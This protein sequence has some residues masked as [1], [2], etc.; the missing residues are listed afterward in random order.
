M[1]DTGSLAQPLGTATSGQALP[2]VVFSITVAG[3]TI[4]A[5]KFDIVGG[6]YGSTGHVQ[7]S[8]SQTALSDAN[9]DL[10]EIT[11]S[12]PGFVEVDITV[13]TNQQGPQQG[14]VTTTETGGPGT[15]QPNEVRIFGGEYLNTKWHMDTDEVVIRARDWSGQLVDQKRILTKIGKAVESALHPLAP[16]RISAAGISN[17]NQKVGNIVTSI[18]N[19]FG[20]NPILNLEG[21]SGNP[22]LGTLY[23]SSDQVYLP[24]PQSLWN[25]LN[26]LARDTGYDVY[27]TPNKDLVFGLPGAGQ[28][29][30]QLIY[31]SPNYADGVNPIRDLIFEHHPRRNSSF[32]VVVISYDPAHAQSVIG[33]A[34]YIGANF[35]G[36]NGLTAGIVTG[37]QAVTA[38]KQI[39]KLNTTSS[40]I[41]LYTFHL[42]GLN[43]QQADLR[44]GTIAR[45]IAKREV[46]ITGSIDGIPSILPTQQVQI[47]GPTIPQQFSG[48]TYYISQY[49]HSF[50]I[51]KGMT[52]R[53]DDGWMTHLTALNIP[54]EAL[55]AATEG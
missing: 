8:T 15:D 44:A 40:Q 7:I 3:K 28:P 6:S 45:D 41:A 48:P 50:S 30:I 21:T 51:P 32:R 34:A 53:G 16:G 9:I 46:I 47:S 1:S 35:A 20:F 5:E 4:P 31:E 27:V 17:E 39:A 43:Q 52:K 14:T 24:T 13:Q 18:A 26:Q 37:Q 25:I 19:E 55:A 11:S 2:E 29:T 12:S 54:T 36:G 42:D 49:R 22:T 38:D 33:R 23:S 10:F